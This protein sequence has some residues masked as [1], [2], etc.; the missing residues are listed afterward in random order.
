MKRIIVA[1]MLAMVVATITAGAAMAAPTNIDPDTL[2][3]P[4]PDGAVCYGSGQYVICQTVF[5]PPVT[6]NEPFL[7][8]PCGTTYLTASDHREVIRWYSDGLLVKKFFTQDVQGTLSLSPTGG[9]PTV[10]FF[11]HES[12]WTN[13]SVPGDEGSGVETVHGLDNRVLV[14]GSGGLIIAGTRSTD[15]PE[16]G[17]FRLEDPRVAD[18]LCEALQP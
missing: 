12:Y 11:A 10:R 3:P 16:H 5:E 1:L 9:G 7:D 2:T 18:A 8:L 14:P 6:A 13:Y 4:P 17:V 15:G